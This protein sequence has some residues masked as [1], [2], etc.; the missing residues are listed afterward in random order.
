MVVVA[1]NVYKEYI[2]EIGIRFNSLRA[3]LTTRPSIGNVVYD[4]RRRS[5]ILISLLVSRSPICY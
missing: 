5:Y 4:G 2:E 3:A 1:L